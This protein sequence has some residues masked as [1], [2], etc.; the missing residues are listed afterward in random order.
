MGIG[1]LEKVK[2]NDDFELRDARRAREAVRLLRQRRFAIGLQLLHAMRDLLPTTRPQPVPA[3]PAGPRAMC[4]RGCAERS[5][6]QHVLAKL[7]AAAGVARADDSVGAALSRRTD[8]V[9]YNVFRHLSALATSV[10][11]SFL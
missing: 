11:F 4:L 8:H 7:L 1:A 10:C 2:A 3:L 6:L 9:L 5:V